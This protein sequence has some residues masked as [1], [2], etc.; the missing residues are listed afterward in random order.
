M[1]FFNR[2]ASAPEP[3]GDF[4]T[5][6][7]GGRHRVAG[8]IADGGFDARLIGEINGAVSTIHPRMAWE[9]APGRTAQHAFCI[10]PEGDPELR[11]AALRWLASAPLPDSPWEYHA[12][13][14]AA[15]KLMGLEIGKRRFDLEEMRAIASWNPSRRRIDVRLWH[16]LF[17]AVP[18]D[19][20]L[21]VGFIFL[22][23]LLGEDDVERWIGAIDLLE[24]PT[25][26][27]TPAELKAEVERR[28][29]E[30][31]GDGSWVLGERTGPGGQVE[32]VRA[33]AALKRIDH[34]F[35]DHHV[36]IAVVWE[37]ASA[38]PSDAE[39]AVLDTEEEDLV[40]RLDGVAVFVG[41]TTTPG[42]RTM[43]FVAEDPDRMRPAIDGWAEGLPDSLA[44]GL[45]P[46]RIKVNF[47]RDMAWSFKGRLGIG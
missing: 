3:A 27:R 19:V 43:H 37:G 36:E 45:P 13:K 14:Q 44:E 21:Q 25:G 34:P 6:W 46:R 24:A 17:D 26:G 31:A 39:A 16:P 41:R 18:A 5:W 42:R 40:A 12:S 11:Q 15:S 33:N 38:L 8:A 47:E 7:S 35:A 23:K 29:G 2:G 30:P 10:S 9:L 28:A 32:I 4:W 20:R 1:R 22:D